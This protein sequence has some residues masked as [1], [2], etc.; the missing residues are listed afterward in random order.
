MPRSPYA[1]DWCGKN[2]SD[3]TDEDLEYCPG[4]GCSECELC[5]DDLDYDP[6]DP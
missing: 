2:L 1:C 5:I 6:N 3:L 4:P